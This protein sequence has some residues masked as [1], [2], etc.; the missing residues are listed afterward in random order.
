MCRESPARSA[1]RVR[2]LEHARV[3]IERDDRGSR[4]AAL[5]A[6]DCGAELRVRA[7]VE[8]RK[9]FERETARQARCAPERDA[10]GLE[11]DRVRRRTSR[12]RAF[13]RRDSRPGASMPAASVSRS[14]ARPVS[15][16]SP[17]RCRSRPELSTLSTKRLSS[18]RSSTRANGSRPSARA[19]SRRV[20]VVAFTGVQR[21]ASH[22]GGRWPRA[23]ASRPALWCG[24]GG[25][26]A[27][28][29]ER[30]AARAAA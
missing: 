5:L 16:R 17:R 13:P 19:G 23:R 14:G 6:G 20:G 27:R 11:R 7:G 22:A 21:K 26:V 30:A 12:S 18:P 24:T 15:T 9:C 29:P 1:L 25:S 28:S 3:A 2:A 8:A 10:G 4:C